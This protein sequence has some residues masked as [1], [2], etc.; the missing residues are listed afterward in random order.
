MSLTSELLPEPLA[1]VTQT[2]APSGISTSMFLR[3]LWRAPMTRS[4]AFASGLSLNCRN[5]S[6][7]RHFDLA[8]A[9]EE[10]A[11]GTA[12]FFGDLVGG[13]EGDDFAAADAGAGA[14]VDEVVGGP[15]RVFVVFDD[16]D[17][18]AEVAEFGERIE[19]ALVVARVEADRGFVEDVEHADEAA[20]DLAGEA[21]ALRFAAGER[22]GGA[23]EREVFEA[24]V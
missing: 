18:V 20:A 2:N 9:A 10:G 24:D 4:D 3:L 13:A 8:L 21:D 1:P 22:G 7:R 16:D 12:W 15:H 11:G 19:Q 14:E 23:F 6:L 5:P 17:R